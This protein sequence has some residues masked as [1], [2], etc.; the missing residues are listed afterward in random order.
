MKVNLAE[1][2]ISASVADAIV[3]SDQVL[4]LPAFHGF[5]TNNK[6]SQEYLATFFDVFNSRNRLGKYNTRALYENL[7]KKHGNH[8]YKEQCNMSR[9]SLILVVYQCI[10]PGGKLASW[11]PVCH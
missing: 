8:F 4:K 6:N 7:I 9:I 5:I 3:F 1:Q 11:V 2:T 10:G